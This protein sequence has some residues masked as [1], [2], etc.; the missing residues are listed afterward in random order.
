MSKISHS[1]LL[2]LWG[3][4]ESLLQSYRSI[5]LSTQSIFISIGTAL[6]IA[7]TKLPVA[8]WGLL[9]ISFLAIYLL[10]AWVT[11]TKQRSAAVNYCQAQVILLEEGQEITKPLQKMNAHLGSSSKNSDGEVAR[12]HLQRLPY[13]F[14][15]LWIV[16]LSFSTYWYMY[17]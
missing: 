8:F 15:L 11:I 9:P 6:S 12:A 7:S 2:R 1:E 17:R 14:L 3:I 10:Y 5:F 13:L 4:Q 16:L